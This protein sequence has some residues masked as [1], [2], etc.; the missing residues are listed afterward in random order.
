MTRIVGGV[1]IAAMVLTSRLVYESIS[2]AVH[3]LPSQVI[4]RH[5]TPFAVC[6]AIY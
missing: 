5:S 6:H 4:S 3:Y 1:D 2:A